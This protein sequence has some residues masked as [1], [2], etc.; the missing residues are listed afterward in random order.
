LRYQTLQ[1]RL[2]SGHVKCMLLYKSMYG[3]CGLSSSLARDWKS[4]Y[5]T[6]A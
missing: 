3:W 5:G 6:V 1:K 2:M 4:N